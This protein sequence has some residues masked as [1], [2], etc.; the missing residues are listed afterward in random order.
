M[1]LIDLQSKSFSKSPL[2]IDN[3]ADRFKT[4][5]D[6]YSFTS[7]SLWTIEK[8]LFYLLKNSKQEDFQSQYKYRPDYLAFDTYGISSLSF[9]IMAVNGVSCIENFNLDT[10]IIPSYDAI[11]SI[12]QDNFPHKK[13]ENLD[14][15]DW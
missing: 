12:C 2:D 1:I 10:V 11:I 14:S 7:P 4:T 3:M 5:N 6:I 15:V 13:P 8:N 9:L